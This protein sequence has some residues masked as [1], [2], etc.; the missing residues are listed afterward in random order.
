V[1]TLTGVFTLP[2]STGGSIVYTAPATNSSTASVS[3]TGPV[4]EATQTLALT[5]PGPPA[6]VSAYTTATTVVVTYN[7]NVTC[8]VGVDAAFAYYYTGVATD[9]I[10]GAA[11]AGNVL[12]LTVAANDPPGSGA[13]IVYT[14]PATNSALVS[15]FATGSVPALYAATQAFVGPWTTPAMVS[16]VVTATTIAI[17]YN[18]ETLLCPNLAGAQ[19]DFAYYSAGTTSGITAVTAAACATD[20]LTLTGTFALPGTGASIVYTAPASPVAG[21]NAVS[22]TSDFPQFAATQTLALTAAPAPAMVSAVVAGSLLT[23]AITYNE[24][25]SC[26]ATGADGDFV[27]DSGFN[28]LGGAISGCS[29]VTNVLTLTGVFNAATGSASI[30]YTAPA[31]SS[32]ANAVYATGST[33]DFAATQTLSPL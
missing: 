2:G 11:C 29:T 31:S 16:A 20:V 18:G 32:V 14:A 4:Y 19:A 25:V 17:T 13:S 10:T 21:T 28:T 24:A 27:Y 30:V 23:I 12:T 15:V 26:P 9:T 8:A 1:L 22:A 3:A 6:M 7:E 33:G 5:P